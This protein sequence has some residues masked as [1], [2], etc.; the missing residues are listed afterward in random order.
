[1]SRAAWPGALLLLA[2]ALSAG[3]ARADLMSDLEKVR[4]GWIDAGA[5]VE[6]S[7]TQFLL[8]GEVRSLRV[9]EALPRSG[10]RNRCRSLV[11]MSERPLSFTLRTP[12]AHP[13]LLPPARKQSEAGLAVIDECGAGPLSGG[14]LELEMGQARG[15]VEI[16]IVSHVTPL[17][18]PSSLLP[19]RAVGPLPPPS[20]IV[21][22]LTLA[23]LD[24]RLARARQAAREDGARLVVT[25][26]TQAEAGGMGAIRLRLSEGCHRLGVLADQA[27]V[28]AAV[29]V[30]AEVRDG[31][32]VLSRDQSHAPDGRLD[33]CLGETA[34]VELR[35][36]GAG[37]PAAIHVV[38]AHWP[39]AP[40]MRADWGARARAAMSWAMHRRRM[41]APAGEPILDL[42]GASGTTKVPLRI[43]P[44]ACYVAAFATLKGEASAARLSVRLGER[45][46]Q[47]DASEEP[48][49]GAVSFCAGGADHHATLQVEL[50]APASWWVASVW[51]VA[52]L[53]G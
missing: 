10:R 27:M 37:G 51:Q 53:G 19:E 35:Y 45:I 43:E 28:T 20:E 30:D 34:E 6:R 11:A 31:D 36:V 41:T 50:R 52:R 4:L 3:P 5:K 33:F 46:H 38:D 18:K 9:G 12:A 26:K 7:E 17:P 13:I 8:A 47:D 39:M 22:P 21:G 16:L 49:S 14:R 48:R 32:V 15:A 42:L 25:V 44:L 29:D 1:M 40:G 2:A 24:E 23:P